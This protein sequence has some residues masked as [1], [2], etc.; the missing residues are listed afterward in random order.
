MLI[1]LLIWLLALL[2]HSVA[3]AGSSGRF[4][5]ANLTE[6]FPSQSE[7]YSTDIRAGVKKR[8][9]AAKMTTTC[10]F[11]EDVAKTASLRE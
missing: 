6:S 3:N 7:K 2:I 10:A 1:V 9:F 11:L 8:T 5:S 4:E